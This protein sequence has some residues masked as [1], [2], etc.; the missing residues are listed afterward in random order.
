MKTRILL[1][2]VISLSIFFAFK[3]EDKKM[4]PISLGAVAPKTDL[5]MMDISGK[6]ISLNDAKKENGLLVIFSCNTCPFVIAWE[7][8]YAG[9]ADIC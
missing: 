7:D 8:R 3:G 6:E 1:I 5:K 4:E 9:L 2:S